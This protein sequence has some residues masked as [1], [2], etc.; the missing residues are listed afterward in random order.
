MLSKDK[1]DRINFLAKKSKSSVLTESE[2]LEQRLLR[3]EY[4]EA[5]RESFRRQLDNIEV[6]YVDDETCVAGETPES[7]QRKR[8]KEKLI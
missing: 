8:I 2:K 6:Q 5:F 7:T 3:E 1:L 4:L